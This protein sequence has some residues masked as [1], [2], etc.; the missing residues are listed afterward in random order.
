MGE[1]IILGT[2]PIEVATEDFSKGYQEGYLRFTTHYQ[3]KSLTSLEVYGFLVRNILDPITSANYRA[4]YIL[5]WS[6]ALHGDDRSDSK[7]GSY[8]AAI[9]GRRGTYE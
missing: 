6:A 3:R 4:G 8:T 1:R 9:R 5:G 2:T 7:G